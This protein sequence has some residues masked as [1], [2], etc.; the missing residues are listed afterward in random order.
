LSISPKEGDL[1]HAFLHQPARLGENA[2]S[3]AAHLCAPCVG[4]HAEGAELV[5]ALL[6]GQ[7]RGRTAPGLRARLQFLELVLGGKIG[8]DD[9][10]AARR[11]RHHVGQAVIGLRPDH[12]IDHRLAR[13]DLLALGLR[14]A[15][16]HAD[17]QIGVGH[18][19]IL[20][21][22]QLGID[23]LG[24]LLADVAGVEQDHV[25][26]FRG[27]HFHVAF[28]PQRLGHALAVID[29]HLA[30]IGAD[31]ELFRIGHVAR[32]PVQDQAGFLPQATPPR[33][34]CIA[35]RNG[36]DSA[37]KPRGQRQACGIHH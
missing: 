12:E 5:A 31:E 34:G 2:R 33:N 35:P 18:L 30:A 14:H 22:A 29:V 7:K 20:V 23:L 6:H 1:A 9:L 25:G 8:V 16:R 28:R 19:Q 10:L 3:G 37:R 17:L 15:A 21:A 4:H 27:R 13:D 26:L 32:A 24:R 11:P 36:G